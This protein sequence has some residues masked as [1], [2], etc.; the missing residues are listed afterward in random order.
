MNV[1]NASR[2]HWHPIPPPQAAPVPAPVPAPAPAP[3]PAAGPED[4]LL[5][6]HCH[7]VEVLMDWLPLALRRWPACVAFLCG[8]PGSGKS[9]WAEKARHALPDTVHVLSYEQG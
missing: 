5:R 8:G 3:A 2:R 7:P 6:A 9:Y 1:K 4:P